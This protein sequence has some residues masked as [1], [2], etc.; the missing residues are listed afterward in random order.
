MSGKPS[1]KDRSEAW[2]PVHKQWLVDGFVWY[3]K[4]L[5][6]KH[7][8]TLALT[9]GSF[10]VFQGTS[11]T[12]LVIFGNHAGWWDPILAALFREAVFPT[13]RL[14]APIDAA[15]LQ[16]Y[17]ILSKMGFYGLDLHSLEGAKTFL[18]I[19]RAILA[20]PDTS[21]WLTPEG[22][23]A[24]VRDRSTPL[25]PGLAHLCSTVPK[26]VAIPLAIEYTFWEERLPEALAILGEPITIEA[27]DKAEWNRLLTERLRVTQDRL[28]SLAIQRD[29]SEFRILLSS[30]RGGASSFDLFRRLGAM[31]RGV[32]Y[33]RQ[34]GKKFEV[35]ET[36]S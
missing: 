27:S 11:E 19:S 32:A 14:Y 34:H 22:R 15:A 36:Q 17:Q 7:F 28:A 10:D 12:P 5:I 1:G 21:I 31:L 3:S 4:R 6:R 13:R 24:D 26:L 33:R 30:A 35:D 25:M 16:Q 9:K 2:I 20:T 18:Q 8:H 23:F 29:A